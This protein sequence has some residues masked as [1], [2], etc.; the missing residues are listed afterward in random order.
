MGRGDAEERPTAP[1]IAFCR[2]GAIGRA[3]RPSM[4]AKS[5]NGLRQASSAKWATSGG[6]EAPQ[7]RHTGARARLGRVRRAPGGPGAPPCSWGGAE[8]PHAPDAAREPPGGLGR[9][10]VACIQVLLH[11]IVFELQSCPIMALMNIFV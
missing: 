4:A 5:P 6:E 7:R 11:L 8:P 9:A 10:Y 1:A 3:Q 2:R